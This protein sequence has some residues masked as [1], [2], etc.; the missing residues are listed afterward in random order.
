[1]CDPVVRYVCAAACLLLG[2][3]AT[4]ATLGLRV[5]P[6][7]SYLIPAATR[8]TAILLYLDGCV[9]LDYGRRTAIIMSLLLATYIFISISA[10]RLSPISPIH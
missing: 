4:F 8:V 1:M 3:G 9:A 6:R 7:V 10:V 5:E 2:A